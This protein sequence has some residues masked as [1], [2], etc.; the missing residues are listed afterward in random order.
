M[1][2][3]AITNNDSVDNGSG[4][5]KIV[6]SDMSSDIKKTNSKCSSPVGGSV[7]FQN[8]MGPLSS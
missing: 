5:T 1:A 2:E 8:Y 3:Y 6:C 7:I 4:N